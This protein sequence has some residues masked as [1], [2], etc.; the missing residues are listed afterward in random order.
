[1]ALPCAPLAPLLY[2]GLSKKGRLELTSKVMPCPSGPP[3]SEQLSKVAEVK[4]VWTWRALPRACMTLLPVLVKMSTGWG[5]QSPFFCNTERGAS[6]LLKQCSGQSALATGVQSMKNAIQICRALR[7][8]L[9]GRPAL[10]WRQQRS[11]ELLLL[12]HA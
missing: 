9:L 2:T 3:P 8:S 4:N 5:G 6:T 7:F 12:D 1:M 11:T 10:S